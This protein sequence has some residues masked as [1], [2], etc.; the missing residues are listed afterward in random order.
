MDKLGELK[1]YGAKDLTAPGWSFIQPITTSHISGHYFESS[2][3]SIHIDVYSCKSIDYIKVLNIVHKHLNLAAW[4][5]NFI[6]RKQNLSTR[7]IATLKGV[8]KKI[9]IKKL[10][11]LSA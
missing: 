9:I 4:T 11:V 7:L 3:P 1:I 8:G 5:G 10:L 2:K 6:V